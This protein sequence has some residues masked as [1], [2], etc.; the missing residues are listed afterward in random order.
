MTEIQQSGNKIASV[1]KLIDD[2]AFQ[3]NL[4]AL[5]ASVEA[6]RA[7]RQGKG[8]SVVADEVRNL[9][10][11]SAKAAHETGEMI[12]AMLSLMDTGTKLAERS[13]RE[14]REIVDAISQVATL[15]EGIAGASDSQSSAMSRIAKSLDQIGDVIQKNSNSAKQMADSANTL[16]RQAEDLRH[17]VSRFRLD[18]SSRT[19]LLGPNVSGGG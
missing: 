16:S 9:S 3:T 7:G 15:F 6:A 17:M 18:P 12:E 10:A 19:R 4:L 2:I 5:N 1:A 8:F 11:R 13:D 14:F